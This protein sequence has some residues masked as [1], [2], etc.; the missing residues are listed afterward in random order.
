V[1]F[2]IKYSLKLI[3]ITANSKAQLNRM[4]AIP[5]YTRMACKPFQGIFGSHASFFNRIAE[6]NPIVPNIKFH[7]RK[8]NLVDLE[9]ND[10]YR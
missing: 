9:K 4:Q 2:G 8:Y 5:T 7:C 3:D 10:Y 1:F 6:E